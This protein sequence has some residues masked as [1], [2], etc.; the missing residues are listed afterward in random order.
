[1]DGD[2]DGAIEYPKRGVLYIATNEQYVNEVYESAET[3][4]RE[5]DLHCTLITDEPREHELVDEVLVREPSDE[6]PV[7][8]YKSH[9]IA[10]T[11]YEQTLYLD[12]DTY[13]KE[14]V[15]ELFDILERYDLAMAQ[16]PVRNTDRLPE[17]PAWFPE[18]NAGVLLFNRKPGRDFFAKWNDNYAELEF[19]QDQPSFRKTLYEA[20]LEYFTLLPEYNVRFWPGFVDETVR[21]VHTHGDNE[22]IADAFQTTEGARAYYFRDGDVVIKKNRTSLTTRARES[23]REN[24]LLPTI[25]KGLGLVT[26]QL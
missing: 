14:D 11:P 25:R 23:L 6:R 24:G 9:N 10:D 18:Y 16:A 1:M 15:T 21:I 26:R 19:D 13:I 7:E 12:S 4:K 5:T 3:L 20:D 8:A 2:N 22:A 17:L